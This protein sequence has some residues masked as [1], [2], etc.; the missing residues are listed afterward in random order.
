MRGIPRLGDVREERVQAHTQRFCNS[1]E[2]VCADASRTRL[3]H[4]D[5]V[6]ACSDSRGELALV[7]AALPPQ[8]T[9]AFSDGRIHGFR[10]VQTTSCCVTHLKPKDKGSVAFG[11]RLLAN[12]VITLITEHG[13]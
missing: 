1:R 9:D 11:T 4:L 12:S 3:E 6:C 10:L 13:R 5:V 2:P 8:S 7:H